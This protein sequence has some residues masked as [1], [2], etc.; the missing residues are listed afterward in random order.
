MQEGLGVDA[1]CQERLAR[2]EAD[3]NRR[4]IKNAAFACGN[5]CSTTAEASR[6]HAIQAAITWRAMVFLV[7]GRDVTH[8]LVRGA[9]RDR[10]NV[11]SDAGAYRR[12]LPGKTS[13]STARDQE[14]Q[15]QQQ[16]KLSRRNFHVFSIAQLRVATL[17][18]INAAAPGE[19]LVNRVS[20]DK[21]RM[22]SQLSLETWG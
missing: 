21:D 7:C 22:I 15:G 13:N 18:Q 2:H 9:R 5:A 6:V 14:D 8:H 4:I 16:P 20:F 17:T 19:R 10:C 1:R 3:C 11:G 12:S